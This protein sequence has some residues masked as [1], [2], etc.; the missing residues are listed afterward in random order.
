MEDHERRGRK[1]RS[2]SVGEARETSGA[3]WSG[4]RGGVDA[5]TSEGE[6]K[7][8]LERALHACSSNGK[9]PSRSGNGRR[10]GKAPLLK[11]VSQKEEEAILRKTTWKFCKGPIMNA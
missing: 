2:S 6:E 10:K 4:T 8:Q 1:R 5:K 9:K 11:K 3:G 7:G